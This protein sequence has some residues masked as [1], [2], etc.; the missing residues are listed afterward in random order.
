MNNIS[1][2]DQTD[3]IQSKFITVDSPEIQNNDVFSVFRAGRGSE[4]N[5]TLEPEAL[6]RGSKSVQDHSFCNSATEA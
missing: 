5:P 1:L 3:W 4:K 6:G 2:D